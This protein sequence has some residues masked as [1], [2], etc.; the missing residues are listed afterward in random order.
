MARK[1]DYSKLSKDELIQLVEKLERKKKYG[2]V[3]DAEHVRE[4][5]VL[6]CKNNLRVLT[7]VKEKEI[8]TSDEEPTHILIEGANYHG[9]SGLNYTHQRTLDLLYIDPPHNTG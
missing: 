4:Q 3:W 6:D 9:L 8:F 7:E 1:K 2:L 5:V